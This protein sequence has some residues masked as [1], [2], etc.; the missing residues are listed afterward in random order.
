MKSNINFRILAVGLTALLALAAIV[1][2]FTSI[3]TLA[4]AMMPG[5]QTNKTSGGA[6]NMTS[7]SK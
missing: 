2:G 5:N 6:D 4:M 7:S 1:V 3:S